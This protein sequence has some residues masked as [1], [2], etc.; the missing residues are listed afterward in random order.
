MLLA[1][2]S[3]IAAET[4]VDVWP[5]GRMPGKDDKTRVVGS[6]TYDAA[7]DAA[8]IVHEFKLYPTGGHGYALHCERDAK[9]WPDD[10][11]KWLLTIGV[12]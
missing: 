10:A 4:I 2:T 5:E 12:K 9:A 7:L 11:L 6:R 1:T 3:L 8:K